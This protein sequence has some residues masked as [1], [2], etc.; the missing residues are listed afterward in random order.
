MFGLHDVFMRMTICLAYMTYLSGIPYV[1]LTC[2][3][4]QDYYMF[5]LHDIFMRMTICLAYMTYLSG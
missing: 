2:R 5:C 3:A 1:R 4:C